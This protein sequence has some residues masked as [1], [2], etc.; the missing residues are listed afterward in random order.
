MIVGWRSVSG[1]LL[2]L[3]LAT[4]FAWTVMETGALAEGA[5]K[6]TADAPKSRADWPTER[7]TVIG[8]RGNLRDWLTNHT[9]RGSEGFADG[10]SPADVNERMEFPWQIY[11]ASGGRLEA[12]FRRIAAPTPHAA[13]QEMDFQVN[14]TWRINDE[15]DVCQ[16]IPRVGWGTEVCFWVDRRGDRIAMYYTECG[17]YTRCFRGRLGPEGELVPGRSFTR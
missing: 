9:L 2:V 16:T 4:I 1:L 14:G 7:V 8:R 3:A 13:M 10:S 17:A 15:G 5:G 11:Y 12:H 6:G